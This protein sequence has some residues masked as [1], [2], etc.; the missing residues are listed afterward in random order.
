MSRTRRATPHRTTIPDAEA[1]AAGRTYWP[2][3]TDW[4]REFVYFLLVDRFC[5][6]PTE[7]GRL[8]DRAQ[9]SAAESPADGPILPWRWCDWAISGRNRFQGGTINGVRDQLR[10]LKDLGV[11]VVYLSPV[12]KQRAADTNSNH[13]GDASD[14]PLFPP[15]SGDLR[16]P[17]ASFN[18]RAVEVPRDS[19]HG[20]SIQDFLDVD[21]RFGT[22][23]DLKALV[24]DA[25]EAGLRVIFDIVINHSAV[26]F[27]YRVPG[28]LPP[29]RPPYWPLGPGDGPETDPGSYRYDFGGWLTVD[30]I[31]LPVDFDGTLDPDAGVW[32]EELQVPGLYNRRGEG[33]YGSGG[34][35]AYNAEYRIADFVNRDFYYPREGPDSEVLEHMVGIWSYWITETD[36]DG[37]RVDTFKHVPW[38]AGAQFVR[39]IREFAAGLG[40]ADFLVAAEVG[41][42]DLTAATYLAVP[43]LRVLELGHRRWSLRELAAGQP[44]DPGAVLDPTTTGL[45]PVPGDFSAEDRDRLARIRDVDLR[46]RVLTSI[47]DHDGL[48]IGQRRIAGQHGP[49]A[50]VPAA[51]L[52]LF[53]PGIPCLYYGTEQA[54][55]GPVACGGLLA[56]RCWW[57]AWGLLHSA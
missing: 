44:A 25:H 39:R 4:R 46:D 51:A 14:D 26:N 35:S 2:S 42:G 38:W 55:A 57:P 18:I 7:R 36:C 12:F 52:L 28:N 15:G 50:V 1:I 43:E 27:A 56:R 41:G 6:G 19:C 30:N 20:Y 31:P 24:A 10:Y 48:G 9:A 33:N 17:S 8:L 22:I 47:D 13:D 40:K 49:G 16:D 5:D 34:F 37:F 23:A 11:T 29:L 54:L 53:A 21:P 32:P 45:G 3:P